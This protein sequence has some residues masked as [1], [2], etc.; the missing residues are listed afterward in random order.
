MKG[1]PILGAIAGL[2]FGVFVALDLVFFRVVTS[3]SVLLV[4]LPIVGLLGG[5][6][7]AA[8]A[9]FGGRSRVSPVDGSAPRTPEG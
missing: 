5:I 7:I 6:A 8:A 4:V 9:P 1:R 2:L 3:D